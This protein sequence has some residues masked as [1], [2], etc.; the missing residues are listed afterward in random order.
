MGMQIY[1][2]NLGKYNEGE[3]SGAW[4][5]PP[6]NMEEMKEKIVLNDEYEEYAIHDYDLPFNINEYTPIHEINRSCT[7]I[8][9]IEETPFMMN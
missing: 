3:L 6:I 7:M 9:E 8:E 1:I 5:H 2:S 4:F